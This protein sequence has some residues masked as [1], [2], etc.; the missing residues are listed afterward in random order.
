MFYAFDYRLDLFHAFVKFQ[1]EKKSQQ[2]R[3]I[4]SNKKV[5]ILAITVI[6]I[7]TVLCMV[8]TH[9]IYMDLWWICKGFLS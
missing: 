7:A 6:F 8:H 2:S 9:V 4:K 1:K 5:R 3:I